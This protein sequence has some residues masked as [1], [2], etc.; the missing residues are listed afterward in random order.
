T[1]NLNVQR[2]L[3]WDIVVEIGYLG[4]LGHK[5]TFPGSRSINQVTPDRITTGNVQRLRPFP[6]FSNAMIHSQ[7]IGNSPYHGI[8]IRFEK[9]M[10]AGLQFTANYTSSKAIDDVTSPNERGGS[11][12]FHNQYDRRADRGLSGNRVAHRFINSA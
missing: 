3:P 2:E 7:T 1:F 6:Q 9:R 4:T 8:N 5:L 11:G 10:A 12:S